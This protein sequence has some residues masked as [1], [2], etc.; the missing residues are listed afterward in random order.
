MYHSRHEECS[1]TLELRLPHGQQCTVGVLF[2]DARH[3]S[4]GHPRCV[5]FLTVKITTC[6]LQKVVPKRNLSCIHLVAQFGHMELMI[7]ILRVLGKSGLQKYLMMTDRSAVVRAR[8]RAGGCVF[9]ANMT[10]TC[11]ELAGRACITLCSTIILS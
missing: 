4:A 3:C 5:I 6:F 9:S 7:T 2:T 10:H 1:T 11:S 8:A